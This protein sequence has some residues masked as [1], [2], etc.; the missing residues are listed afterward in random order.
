MQLEGSIDNFVTKEL[1]V[2]FTQF[3]ESTDV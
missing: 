1:L 2:V 3:F